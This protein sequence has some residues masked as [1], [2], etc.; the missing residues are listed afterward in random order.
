MY[1]LNSMHKLRKS[2]AIPF[3]RAKARVGVGGQLVVADVR[4]DLG[5]QHRDAVLQR[6]P[7][8]VG[9]LGRNALWKDGQLVHQPG[10]KCYELQLND[11]TRG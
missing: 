8:Q 3:Q 2:H 7:A 11:N 6:P 9:L 5:T 4:L 10:M 1:I